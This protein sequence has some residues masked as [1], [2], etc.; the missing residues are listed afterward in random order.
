MC[1]KKRVKVDIKSRKDRLL[2]K[3]LKKSIKAEK[4]PTAQNKKREKRAQIKE[5]NATQKK[6]RKEP[7]KREKK[8]YK[9]KKTLKNLRFRYC[10]LL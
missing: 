2:K 5:I 8:T 4:N 6:Q 1:V 9:M 10:K 7:I 3:I